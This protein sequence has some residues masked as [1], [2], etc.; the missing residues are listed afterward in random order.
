MMGFVCSK[1]AVSSEYELKSSSLSF[2]FTKIVKFAHKLSGSI[3]IVNFG[4]VRISE[5]NV[6]HQFKEENLPFQLINLRGD[7]NSEIT[8]RKSAILTVDSVNSLISINRRI[9]YKR[10]LIL[11]VFCQEATVD[12]ILML[13]E[14]YGTWNQYFVVEQENYIRLLTFVWYTPEACG[15]P[16]LIEVNRYDKKLK[17]WL[18]DQFIVK[19]FENFYNCRLVFGVLDGRAGIGSEISAEPE[20]MLS[21]YRDRIISELSLSLKFKIKYQSAKHYAI[22]EKNIFKSVNLLLKMGCLSDMSELNSKTIKNPLIYTDVS[23]AVPPGKSYSGF[24]KLILPFDYDTWIWIAIT[25]FI[26]Y[27]TIMIVYLSTDKI[28]TTVFGNKISTPSLNVTAIFFGVSQLT[29][30]TSSFARFLVMVFILY[31]LIIRTAWQAK[32]F[33]FLQQDISKPGIKSIEEMIDSDA[34]LYML[35]SNNLNFILNNFGRQ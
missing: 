19:K 1:L 10:T 35:Q 13:E 5:L 2:A 22:D 30:P 18:T 26:A 33:E 29:L 9:I 21:A 3:E 27:F 17:N 31:T 15:K 34:K 12:D 14:T 32:M 25:F 23:V 6:L 11:F 4:D 24:E 16:Q 7:A 20:T 8:F 28:K